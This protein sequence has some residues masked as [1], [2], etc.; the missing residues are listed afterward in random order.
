VGWGFVVQL[1]GFAAH[2]V[3]GPTEVQ[4]MLR[5]VVHS[6]NLSST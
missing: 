6:H 1:G 5:D 3:V 4:A 2:M